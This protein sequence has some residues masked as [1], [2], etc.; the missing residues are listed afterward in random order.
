[1]KLTVTSSPHIRGDF[2]TSRLMLDV[3]LALIPA[4][5][6]GT[7]VLGF[8]AL[9]VTLISMAAAVVAE[10][11]YSLCLRKRNSGFGFFRLPTE[12]LRKVFIAGNDERS[13]NFK[14]LTL[15]RSA[16]F[17][18][19]IA[20]LQVFKG[21]CVPAFDSVI[22]QFFVI[23][24]LNLFFVVNV[25]QLSSVHRKYRPSFLCVLTMPIGKKGRESNTRMKSY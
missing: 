19:V 12:E 18:N 13:R 11:L 9:L 16:G 5:I 10:Y 7:L 23:E 8:R 1:M 15:L 14:L 20:F 3:V 25:N 6:V 2:R 21:F 24:V 4:L 17:G 22:N